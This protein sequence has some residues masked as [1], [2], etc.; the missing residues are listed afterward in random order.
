MKVILA[1]ALCMTSASAFMSPAV[2]VR[3]AIGGVK[4]LMATVAEKPVE[5]KA[6]SLDEPITKEEVRAAVKAW[7][8]GIIDI[9]K[10]FIDGGDYKAKAMEVL[11]ASYAFDDVP[12]GS[13]LLFKPT[14]ANERNF[15]HEWDEFMSYFV[16]DGCYS[17]DV[18]FAIKPW[19]KIRFDVHG[20]FIPPAGNTATVSGIYFFTPKADPETEVKVE[21]TFQFIRAKSPQGKLKIVLHH[22]SVP[23]SP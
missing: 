9:S 3:S 19:I 11:Q 23:F 6:K 4:P 10:V 21:Y 5:A 22:S 1:L 15:R 14:L 17:E 8:E 16:G 2:P 20:V 18:G 7:T 13:K 12:A